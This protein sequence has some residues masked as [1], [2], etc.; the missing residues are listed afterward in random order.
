MIKSDDN[1]KVASDKTSV[2]VDAQKKLEFK[3]V[4]ADGYTLDTVKAQSNG[5]QIQL[6]EKADDTY[7][8][9]AA[10]VADGLEIDVTTEVVKNEEAT[11][12]ESATEEGSEEAAEEE[13]EED[14]AE[15]DS[16]ESTE[17]EE[18]TEEE[19]TPEEEATNEVA[20]E[21]A[22]AME[23]AAG[24]IASVMMLKASTPVDV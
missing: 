11:E 2:K 5:A 1:K 9:D 23:S 20:D 14:A 3:A 17:G 18:A 7:V 12:E 21:A 15:A 13:T 8:V 19:S 10:N 16:E 22:N 24:A 6:T 4:A